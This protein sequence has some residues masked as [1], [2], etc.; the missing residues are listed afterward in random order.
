MRRA[1][2]D[3]L[4]TER[5]THRGPGENGPDATVDSGG[6]HD[7]VGSAL[8]RVARR[9]STHEIKRMRRHIERLEP[10]MGPDSARTAQHPH[11]RKLGEPA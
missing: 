9:Q 4:M 2:Y 5:G 10:V 8:C 7:T 6:P 11:E 1:R 3:P